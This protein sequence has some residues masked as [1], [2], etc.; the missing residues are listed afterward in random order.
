MVSG[1]RIEYSDFAVR[2]RPDGAGHCSEVLWTPDGLGRGR[3][4][5]V[6]PFTRLE[7]PVLL[8]D[9]ARGIH[10]DSEDPPRHL[11]APPDATCRRYDARE[12]GARLFQSLFREDVKTAFALKKSRAGASGLRIRLVIDPLQNGCAAIA[13]LPWELLYDPASTGYL[14]LQRD[15]PVV[16][17]LEGPDP[18]PAR[19]LI[20]KLRVLAAICSPRDLPRLDGSAERTAVQRWLGIP[21][22]HP[23]VLD[24]ATLDEVVSRLL[25]E[26]FHVLHFSGHG[27]FSHGSGT[28]AF[29]RPDGTAEKLDAEFLAAALAG[30]P[31]LRL[32]V[33]NAC[34]SDRSPRDL[35]TD[36]FSGIVSALI[37]SRVPA[38]VGMQFP[39]SDRAAARFAEVLY[40]SLAAGNPIDAAVTEGRLALRRYGSGLEWATPTLHLRVSDGHL[41]ERTDPGSAML[42]AEPEPQPT[43]PT[44]P[45]QL[46]AL[47][48]RPRAYRIRPLAASAALVLLTALGW[49]TWRLTRLDEPEVQARTADPADAE[50]PAA[51]AGVPD[52]QVAPDWVCPAHELLPGFEWIYVPAGSLELPPDEAGRT[53]PLLIV[54]EAFCIGRYEITRGQQRSVLPDEAEPAGDDGTDDRL[55]ASGV[56]FDLAQR[57]VDRL[58]ERHRDPLYRLPTDAEWEYA[59][60]AGSKAAYSFGNDAAELYLHGNC[61]GR[62]GI[63]DGFEDALA[64]VG[65][66]QPNML[67]L[68]DVH[69]NVWEW[70][71]DRPDASL[72]PDQ[73]LRRGGS[74]KTIPET[75]AFASS[76]PV[77][78]DFKHQDS[79]FRI[80]REPAA[81]Y[82]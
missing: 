79:G 21:G 48:P 29:E 66:Y 31:A 1:R 32:V 62:G 37:R 42:P 74:Y 9:L 7:I 26:E 12:V 2:I 78:G 75:C 53:P 20:G 45:L 81:P 70:V 80:V 16:R 30:A 82:Q 77:Q 44:P 58:N 68:C 8:R 60:R 17:F 46:V 25:A 47:E 33:V 36:P 5:F 73:R 19:P 11:E 40:A 72:G 4:P 55:P 6:P 24:H 43:E 65:H 3:A 14:S 35:G 64:P 76:S 56:S 69:G 23:E 71:S 28:L 34:E 22:V 27:G 49:A 13:A 10:A 61:L 51:G 41:F 15:S 54:P 18:P 67:G 57:F 52:G 50:P 59:A 38:V 39:I 63:H